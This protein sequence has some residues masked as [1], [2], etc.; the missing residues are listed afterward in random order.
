MENHH[1]QGE[2][3]LY[4]AIFNSYVKLPEGK[5]C[6]SDPLMCVLVHRQIITAHVWLIESQ[7]NIATH[8]SLKKTKQLCLGDKT[9]CFR[10]IHACC[11]IILFI[12]KKYC[13]LVVSTPLTRKSV[14]IMTFPIYGKSKKSG[15]KPPTRSLLSHVIPTIS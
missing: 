2:N 9:Y 11:L 4:M 12:T 14:G 6:C 5:H 15:S 3:P 8:C 7:Y 10:G 1:F 13:W